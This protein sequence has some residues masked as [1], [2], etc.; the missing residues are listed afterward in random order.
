MKESI[1]R[2]ALDGS[3]S[4]QLSIDG[5]SNYEIPQKLVKEEIQLVDGNQDKDEDANERPKNKAP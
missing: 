1:I 5:I 4:A 2:I 3:K